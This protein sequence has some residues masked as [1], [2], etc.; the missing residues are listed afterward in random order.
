[1]DMLV[2]LTGKSFED[3]DVVM[4]NEAESMTYDTSYQS[5]AKNFK[6]GSVHPIEK[7]KNIFLASMALI[8]LFSMIRFRRKK[9]NIG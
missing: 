5:I 4:V 8:S 1:M 2:Y 9:Q 3:W 6:P 7:G